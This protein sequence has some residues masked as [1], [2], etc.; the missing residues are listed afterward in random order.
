MEQQLAGQVAAPGW[1]DDATGQLRWWDGNAWQGYAWQYGYQDPRHV[2]QVQY[3]GRVANQMP[4]SYTRQ[5]QGHSLTKTLLA[6]LFIVGIPFLIYWSA[7][8]NHYWHT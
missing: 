4:V 2:Q 8:P 5:Q 6:S 1:Y 7:S 3:A